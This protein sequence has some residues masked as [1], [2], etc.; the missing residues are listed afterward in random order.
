MLL[1]THTWIWFAADVPRR[2]GPRTRR[3]LE[4]ARPPRAPFVSTASIFEI[5]ALHT[6]GRLQF[7]LP[8]ERWIRDSI[9]RAGLRVIDIEAGI[10]VDAAQVTRA[11]LADPIDRLLVATAREYQAPLVTC[12]RQI[13]DYAA[14]TGLVRVVDGA[15]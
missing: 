14:R 7:T 4:K 13:L 12:D 15:A 8:V 10:A 1:D 5:V 2:L 6:A 9:D 11:A 3:Q